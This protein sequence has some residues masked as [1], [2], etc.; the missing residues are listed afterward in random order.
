MSSRRPDLQDFKDADHENGRCRS[1]QPISCI[2]QTER[3]PEQD[4]SERML[5]I[6]TKIG[7]RTQARRSQC[8]EG[9]GGG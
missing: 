3:Q 2:G 4:K 1:K 5:A 6:L 8:C 7:M 9:D